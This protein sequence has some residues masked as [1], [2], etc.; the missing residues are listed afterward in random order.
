[1]ARQPEKR[2][3]RAWIST[4]ELHAWFHGVAVWGD[5]GHEASEMVRLASPRERLKAPSYTLDA[6]FS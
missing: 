6:E 4:D 3:R 1:M 2:F 5:V